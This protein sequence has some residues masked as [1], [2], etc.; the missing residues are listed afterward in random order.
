MR[1][2]YYTRQYYMVNW[3]PAKAMV[4]FAIALIL[5]SIFVFWSLS[6]VRLQDPSISD[7]DI[8]TT[9][10]QATVEVISAGNSVDYFIVYVNDTE[11]TRLQPVDGEIVQF[12]IETDDT[13]RVTS[14]TQNGTESEIESTT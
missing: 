12:Q 13:I 9:N 4:V 11:K 14:V 1:S 7:V 8:Q 3:T 10:S 6:D 5:M 2:V